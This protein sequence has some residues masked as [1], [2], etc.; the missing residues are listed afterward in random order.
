LNYTY[1]YFNDEAGEIDAK[2]FT[3]C[4]CKK[5]VICTIMTNSNYQGV[6]LHAVSH[7]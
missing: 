5:N 3:D 4:E 7:A 6:L 2:I 1:F